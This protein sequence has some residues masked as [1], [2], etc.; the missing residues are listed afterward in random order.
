[1]SSS[2][3]P[4][5]HCIYRGD[6]DKFPSDISK[7]ERTK[8]DEIYCNCGESKTFTYDREN[9]Q[10]RCMKN[11]DFRQQTGMCVW[12]DEYTGKCYGISRRP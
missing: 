4:S 5:I 10:G 9:H 3:S 1:M 2:L 6:V 12:V 11:N 7:S 8:C